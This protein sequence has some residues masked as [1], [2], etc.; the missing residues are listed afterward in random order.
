VVSTRVDVTSLPHSAP[1]FAGLDDKQGVNQLMA[2]RQT[3]S[4]VNLDE[5]MVQESL[6]HVH[7]GCD[8]LVKTLINK[9]YRYIANDIR[10]IYIFF[11]AVASSISM[12][13]RPKS[14]RMPN[15]AYML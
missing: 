7:P 13:A 14:Y 12:I 6:A 9:G 3:P 10:Y 15:N 4:T 8:P 1:G 5:I 2:T 11:A